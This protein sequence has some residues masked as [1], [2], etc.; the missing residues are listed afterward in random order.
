M[1]VEG[2]YLKIVPAEKTCTKVPQ[3]GNIPGKGKNTKC[4]LF[5]DFFFFLKK[6]DGER[7]QGP[8]TLPIPCIPESCIE[9]K[10]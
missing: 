10:I 1:G 4:I 5:S 9:I 8:L 2:T 6:T 7:Q 3:K